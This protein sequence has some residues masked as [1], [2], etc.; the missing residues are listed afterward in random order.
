L[1]N[2]LFSVSFIMKKNSKN[3]YAENLNPD[4]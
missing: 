1:K 3:P 2:I 4:I